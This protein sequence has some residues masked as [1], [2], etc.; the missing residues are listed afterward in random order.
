[1]LAQADYVSSDK[2]LSTVTD[3]PNKYSLHTWHVLLRKCANCL[4]L[5]SQLPDCLLLDLAS[6][7]INVDGFYRQYF[8]TKN[9]I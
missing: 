1:M 8:K 2:Q 9:L 7:Y 6:M 4:V 3:R 5:S